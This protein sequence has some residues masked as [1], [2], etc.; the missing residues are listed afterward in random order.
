MARSAPLEFLEEC[1]ARYKKEVRGYRATLVKKEFVAGRE[2]VE[3]VIKVWFK[4]EPFSVRMEWEKGWG[5]ASR[6]LYVKGENDG[7]MLAKLVGPLAFGGL[8]PRDPNGTEA[9]SAARYPI[10]EFG[11][12]VG[13]L[14]TLKYWQAASDKR[15]L[16]TEYGGL[17]YVPELGKKCWMLRRLDYAR[18]EVDGIMSATF[19]FDPATWLQVGSVLRDKDG[20]LIGRY[21]F[22]NVRLNPEFPPDTFTRAG[23]LR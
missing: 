20:K 3:E 22:K 5:L 8:A 2:Q 6:T 11:I 23:L 14:S 17:A 19:Y 13:T 9:R 12:Q 18:P 4:E 21:F 16:R 15:E 1:I 10:T 7:M